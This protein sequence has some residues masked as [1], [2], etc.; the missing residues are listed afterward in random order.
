MIGNNYHD[1]ELFHSSS[2]KPA[3]QILKV[4]KTLE[5]RNREKNDKQ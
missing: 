5:Q 4:M 3:Q 1:L 2:G